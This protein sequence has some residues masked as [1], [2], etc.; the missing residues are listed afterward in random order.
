[1]VS[2]QRKHKRRRHRRVCANCEEI[3]TDLAIK[4]PRCNLLTPRPMHLVAFTTIAILVAV[5]LLKSIE[6]I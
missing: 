6:L 5:A 1:M 3:L 2:V 4:C